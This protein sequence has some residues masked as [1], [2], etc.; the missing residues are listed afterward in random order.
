MLLDNNEEGMSGEIIDCLFEEIKQEL[1]PLV[2]KITKK[3][4]ELKSE[5]EPDFS[6]NYDIYRQKE[7][8]RYLLEYIGF[9][10]DSGVMAESEHP[11]TT[12]LSIRM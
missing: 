7:F 1:I 10:F 6:G 11:F 2:K 12:A 5:I 3:K 4:Q 8:S 9:S